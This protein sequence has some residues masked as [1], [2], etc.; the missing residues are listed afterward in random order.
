MLLLGDRPVA[1]K[2]LRTALYIALFAMLCA[3]WADRH[4]SLPQELQDWV[5]L[6]FGGLL[7]AITAL[8]VKD[9]TTISI[10]SPIERA[11]DPFRFW[12]TIVIS[13]GLGGAV[14]IGAAGGLLRLWKF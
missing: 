10:V 4:H 11:K 8:D 1:L 5:W 2:N 6:A 9:G 7:V 3:H 13:A 14:A 12:T